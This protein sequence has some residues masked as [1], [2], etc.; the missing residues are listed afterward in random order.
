M[1]IFFQIISW[2]G[3]ILLIL[4]MFFTQELVLYIRKGRDVPKVLEFNWMRLWFKY[5]V[6][7]SG[8]YFLVY[9]IINI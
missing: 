4:G 2:I 8:V 1:E 9:I 5:S 6:I 3:T 7:A